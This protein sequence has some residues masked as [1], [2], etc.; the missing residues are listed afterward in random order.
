MTPT[1]TVKEAKDIGY[2]VMIVPGVCLAPVLESCTNAL[3]YLKTEG[4]LPPRSKDGGKVITAFNVCG[5]Q[6]CIQI[7]QRAG[8]KAYDTV[9]KK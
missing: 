6:E 9:G 3:E 1:W 5:L 2:R 4:A 8:G 7:D